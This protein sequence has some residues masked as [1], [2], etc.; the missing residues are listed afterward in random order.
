MQN[1]LSRPNGSC[2]LMPADSDAITK[3]TN[4][5]DRAL[6]SRRDSRNWAYLVFDG[7]RELRG[8]FSEYEPAKI[9]W[10]NACDGGLVA[11]EYID[12]PE[13][14]EVYGLGEPAPLPAMFDNKV[15]V[16]LA[17]NIEFMAMFS[18]RKKAV[19][20]ARFSS[21]YIVQDW[22]IDE[23]NELMTWG[24]AGWELTALGKEYNTSGKQSKI[25]ASIPRVVANIEVAAK[26]VCV[27]SAL[28]VVH[29][30]LIYIYIMQ[31]MRK[32][33]SVAAVRHLLLRRRRQRRRTVTSGGQTAKH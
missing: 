33:R 17:D 3:S 15:Y 9:F 6:A 10:K 29:G 11:K 16:V 12:D 26:G 28:L 31:C 5:M 4:K 18:D 21:E 1:V 20:Y 30:A 19:E 14:F 27:G 13:V 22:T 23:D 2:W 32:T 8:I 7:N 24:F 25:T